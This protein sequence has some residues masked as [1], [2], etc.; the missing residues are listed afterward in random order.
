VEVAVGGDRIIQTD[1]NIPPPKGIFRHHQQIKRLKT[2]Y[3]LFPYYVRGSY[4]YIAYG[5]FELLVD[6]L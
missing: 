3:F 4:I 6:L 1:M 2:V 5:R